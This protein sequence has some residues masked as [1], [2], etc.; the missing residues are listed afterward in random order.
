MELKLLKKPD[1]KNVVK[2]L[3]ELV[4]FCWNTPYS[5]LSDSGTEFVN[6]D[7]K[8]ALENYSI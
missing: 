7:L 2:A 3:E 6:Q 8:Q 1:S 4:I 5:L